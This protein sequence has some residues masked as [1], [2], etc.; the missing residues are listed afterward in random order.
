ML[1]KGNKKAGTRT[2]KAGKAGKRIGLTPEAF[3]QVLLKYA[4]RHAR[5][6][7]PFSVLRLDITDYARLSAESD[8][9]YGEQLNHF[10][11]DICQRSLRGFDRL[12]NVSPGTFLILLPETGKTS[13]ELACHGLSHILSTTKIRICDQEIVPK[14]RTS[15]SHFDDCQFDLDMLLDNVGYH[16][17]RHG[18]LSPRPSAN[19][20]SQEATAL[21]CLTAWMERYTQKSKAQPRQVGG[22]DLL[23]WKCA[24]SW[25]PGVEVDMR[26]IDLGSGGA[27]TFALEDLIKKSR[28]LQALDHPSVLGLRDFCFE[29]GGQFYLVIEAVSGIHLDEYLASTSC[30]SDK[31]FNWI[32]SILNGVIYLLSVL[33]PVTITPFT[34]A[35]LLV[36]TSDR[37][38]IVDYQTPYIFQAQSSASPYKL[39][40][41][42]ASLILLICRQMQTKAAS[43]IRQLCLN[44]VESEH[45][46]HLSTPHKFRS[47]VQMIIEKDTHQDRHISLNR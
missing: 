24:D 32:S 12:C 41:N 34:A 35:H 46:G 4:S 2:G 14:Y 40:A 37:V 22:I 45:Q 11:L 28:A 17:D 30:P 10:C 9:N 15:M 1:E 21:S 33:P 47:A 29:P 23:E 6:G 39:T 18:N 42:L 38:I 13:A 25:D 8:S 43:E 44:I 5:N 7:K 31:A 20:K 36:T 19:H 27:A 26:K 3:K 16:I